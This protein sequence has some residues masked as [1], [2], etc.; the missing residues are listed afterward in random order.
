M[1]DIP[2]IERLIRILQILSSGR[3]ITTKELVRRFDN[4]IPLRTIQ[5]DLISLQQSGIPIDSN[6]T[7]A[8]ENEWFLVSR[9]KSFIPIP[10]N[11]HEYLAAHILKANLRVFRN[12][13][14]KHE[15]D[16]LI[17]KIDQLVPDD[18][19][20]E[21]E[22]GK[23]SEFFESYST[24]DFDYSP[25]NQIIENLVSAISEKRNCLVTYDN[26]QENISKT[27]R[28]E[29]E[30]LVYYNGALYALVYFRHYESY[31]LL[32]VQRILK[33]KV[34]DEMYVRDHVFDHEEFWKGRFGLFP[35]ERKKV[36]LKFDKS[37]TYHID[38]RMWHESQNIKYD[39][40]KNLILTLEVALS[41]ELITW[42]MGWHEYITVVEPEELILIIKEKAQIILDNYK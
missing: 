23:F 33:L 40:K 15:V 26:P 8:N 14:F 2:Q 27:Y 10:L 7:V 4:E 32:A 19:F 28:V 6:K 22:K 36:K 1:S 24:G 20:L 39:K 17:R 9:Y 13:S 12:T 18:L 3:R 38:G 25:Y 29:P 41:P 35:G 30:K 5:R 11:T 34:F 31:I 16:S 21:A 42:I 37:I